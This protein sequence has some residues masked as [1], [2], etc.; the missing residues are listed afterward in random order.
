MLAAGPPATPVERLRAELAETL[1]G[2]VDAAFDPLRGTQGRRDQLA[3]LI[4]AAQTPQVRC[5]PHPQ[6]LICV[7]HYL[8]LGL[9]MIRVEVRN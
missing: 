4:G 7:L 9:G 2:V 3:R 6:L 8:G 5:S 1:E